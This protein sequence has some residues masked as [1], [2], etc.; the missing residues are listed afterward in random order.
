MLKTI[1]VRD[2]SIRCRKKIK[3]ID[4]DIND[5]IDTKWKKIKDT[6]QIVAESEVGKLKTARKPWFNDVCE[7]ALNWRKEAIIQWLNN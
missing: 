3:R 1:H 6:M 7:D 2:S 4:T 5:S